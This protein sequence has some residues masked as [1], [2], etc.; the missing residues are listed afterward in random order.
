MFADRFPNPVPTRTTGV[1]ASMIGL[2]V[3]F[4]CGRAPE[5]QPA[6]PI[7]PASAAEPSTPAAGPFPYQLGVARDR[8]VVVVVESTGWTE[9]IEVTLELALQ[10]AIPGGR[11]RCGDDVLPCPNPTRLPS[12]AWTSPGRSVLP[13]AP[14]T[15]DQVGP[16][17]VRPAGADAPALG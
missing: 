3:A 17:S 12:L 8:N 10:R 11:G 5:A 6:S 14:S 2:T 9:R 13:L 15:P 1:V 4:G 16:Y 7:G